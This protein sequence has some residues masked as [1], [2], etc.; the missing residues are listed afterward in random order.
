[1]VEWIKSCTKQQLLLGFSLTRQELQQV[2]IR[3]NES[4]LMNKGHDSISKEN[5]TKALLKIQRET[6]LA[7][8]FTVDMLETVLWETN[9]LLPLNAGCDMLRFNT[10]NFKK[11]IQ[12]DLSK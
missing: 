2:L 12:D 10:K 7:R 4:G 5:L 6:Q 1:M 8:G 9:F 11:V 3:I